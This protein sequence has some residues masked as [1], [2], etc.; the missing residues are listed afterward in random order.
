MM[1]GREQAPRRRDLEG[2]VARLVWLRL[3]VAIGVMAGL[4][5]E[6]ARYKLFLLTGQSNSLGTTNAGESDITPGTDP[7]DA[8]IRFFWHNFASA[9]TSLGDSGGVFTNLQSQ[10][11]GYYTGSPLHW[12]PE[13]SFGRGL[14]RAGV[15]T[16]E[17]SSAA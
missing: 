10:Q 1:T 12:G 3:L 15:S 2:S 4:P 11:G 8:H 14:Y 6:A 9:T 13:I 7:A 16:S 5:L 17:L